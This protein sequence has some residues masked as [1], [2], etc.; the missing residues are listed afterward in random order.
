VRRSF[1]PVRRSRP[2]LA[3]R[4]EDVLEGAEVSEL[5]FANNAAQHRREHRQGP[6]SLEARIPMDART[7]V[8]GL[9]GSA[10]FDQEGSLEGPIVVLTLEWVKHGNFVGEPHR[11]TRTPDRGEQ[12]RAYPQRP[13]W[14]DAQAL[15]GA[16]PP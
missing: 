4:F 1:P 3:L 16:P 9:D 12:A 11:L 5:A 13:L 14:L 7:T 15:E 8:A 6:A 2:V 10:T